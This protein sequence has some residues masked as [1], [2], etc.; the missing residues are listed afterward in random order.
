MDII[1]HYSWP[2]YEKVR[3]RLIYFFLLIPLC[4]YYGILKIF[5]QTL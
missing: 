1:V 5:L 3:Q 4:E 2:K